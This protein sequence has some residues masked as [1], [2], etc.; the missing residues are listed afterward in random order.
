MAGDACQAET[1]RAGRQPRATE[2][3]R[4]GGDANGKRE[5]VVT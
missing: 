4:G 5:K 2:W 3:F 1:E